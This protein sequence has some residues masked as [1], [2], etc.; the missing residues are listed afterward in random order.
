MTNYNKLP[1]EKNNSS[2]KLAN[3]VSSRQ[4]N[5][6]T[7]EASEVLHHNFNNL[8][9]EQKE[10]I[11][12]ELRELF[13]ERE[14]YIDKGSLNIIYGIQE[15]QG[16]SFGNGFYTCLRIMHNNLIKEKIKGFQ[17]GEK[18]AIKII[19]EEIEFLKNLQNY[20]ASPFQ[21]KTFRI[22]IEELKKQRE[23]LEWEN[24]LE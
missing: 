4:E 7:S 11:T 8:T 6:I 23:H 24:R 10:S 5:E 18:K 3:R 12:R 17:E 14:K 9:I 21:I 16:G 20:P 13:E 2:E 1:Q 15:V 22:A 19:D